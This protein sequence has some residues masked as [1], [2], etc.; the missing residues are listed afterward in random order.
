MAIDCIEEVLG[1]VELSNWFGG[2][3][4]FHDAYMALQIDS[5]GTGWLKAYAWRMTSE[6]DENGFFV[7]EKHFACTFRFAGIKSFS[8]IDFLPGLVILGQLDINKKE[9]GFEVDFRDTAY[10]LSGSLTCDDIRLTFE[11][12]AKAS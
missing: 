7:C 12:G 9:H 6:V 4:S 2:F 5:D 10:G 3:P 8:A 11:P 1:A